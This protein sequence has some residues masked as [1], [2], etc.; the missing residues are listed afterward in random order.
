[1]S[2]DEYN[3]LYNLYY[4]FQIEFSFKD[5]RKLCSKTS[6]KSYHN[7]CIR[8]HIILYVRFIT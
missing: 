3:V 5:P 6:M 8:Y 1:M 4:N 2:T 7:C